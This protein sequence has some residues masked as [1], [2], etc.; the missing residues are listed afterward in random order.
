MRP[1]GP[2][3][4]CSTRRAIRSVFACYWFQLRIL[5]HRTHLIGGPIGR[6]GQ[7]SPQLF[8]HLSQSAQRPIEMK[9]AGVDNRNG[10]LIAPPFPVHAPHA[11][12][13]DK[14]E[15]YPSR[16][17]R[18]TRVGTSRFF[19]QGGPF[20]AGEYWPSRPDTASLGRGRLGRCFLARFV[21]GTF[22]L[23]G[24]LKQKLAGLGVA[25]FAPLH[26]GQSQRNGQPF[27]RP[28][29]PD[30]AQAPLLV[31]GGAVG[32]DASAVRRQVLSMPTR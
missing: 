14:R 24:Q 20:V 4:A 7:R 18:A 1:I 19:T 16:A 26:A 22:R 30:V 32:I 29:D 10:T 17:N 21:A 15:V 12:A 3:S 11:A 31:D 27:L 25:Q 9:I 8:G 23:P 6:I 28:R 13:G 5:T 2:P